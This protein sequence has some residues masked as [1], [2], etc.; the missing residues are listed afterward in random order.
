VLPFALL[1]ADRALSKQQDRLDERRRRFGLFAVFVAYL[2]LAIAMRRGLHAPDAGPLRPVDEIWRSARLDATAYW[3][4]TF[5]IFDPRDPTVYWLHRTAGEPFA[6]VTAVLLLV[7]VILWV[8]RHPVGWLGLTV[9]GLFLLAPWLMRATV[10]Q[11]NL[12]TLRQ[13]YLPVLL[14]APLVA[15][16]LWSR[17]RERTLLRG[18]AILSLVALSGQ[19]LL[20]GGVQTTRIP[21]RQLASSLREVTAEI[22]AD[23]TIVCIGNDVCGE[24]PSLVAS[25]PSIFAIPTTV[26]D[27]TPALIPLDAHSLLAR[28]P[29]SELDVLTEEQQ[30]VRSPEEERGP[31]WIVQ[32]PPPLV[33][34]GSQRIPGATV[35]IAER[36]ERGI[37]AI[38][39][40][41]DRPLSQLAFL[42]LH[43]CQPPERVALGILGK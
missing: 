11:L 24:S 9:F 29:E 42:R 5:G 20:S 16:A 32:R 23:Q 40:Q 21:Q 3:L 35:S 7:G 25:N 19:S 4:K 43:G 10:S 2:P 30:P 14:G 33:V 34:F 17:V 18:G 41:F 12:P 26:D 22:P 15:V 8:R 27:A 39:Y 38:R 28:A 1:L 31:T 36:S 6:I 37:R 13:I